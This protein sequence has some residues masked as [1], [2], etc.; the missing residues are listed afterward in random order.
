M[1][2]CATTCASCLLESSGH[3]S[4]ALLGLLICVHSRRKSLQLARMH[5]A[6]QDR[7]SLQCARL[8]T[9][10]RGRR[11]FRC[12][13]TGYAASQDA[14][15]ALTYH[16]ILQC[17]SRCPEDAQLAE[18]RILAPMGCSHKCDHPAAS[19]STV[20]KGRPPLGAQTLI[21]QSQALS[22][23]ASSSQP[24]TLG[25]F[26]LQVSRYRCHIG[27]SMSSEHIPEPLPQDVV[28]TRWT[29]SP[30]QGSFAHETAPPAV[31]A[32]YRPLGTIRVQRHAQQFVGSR[33]QQGGATGCT[34]LSQTGS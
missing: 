33:N 24:S 5:K 9:R 27:A 20:R 1:G 18:P 11:Y 19:P 3:F 14:V 34:I 16:R 32:L 29:R 13:W 28:D 23:R 17:N 30:L 22:T 8:P 12:R 7:S 10:P 6:V 15:P 2:P 26:S 4:S 25:A 31:T 21:P